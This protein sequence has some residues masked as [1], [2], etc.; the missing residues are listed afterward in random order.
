MKS[1]HPIHVEVS[2][3][4]HDEPLERM[5]KRFTKKMKKH[6]ILEE[7]RRKRYYEK[8]SAKRQRMA[9]ERK[10][11]LNKLRAVKDKKEKIR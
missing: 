5:I 4:Y 8:P 2:P 11:V 1:K 3:K 10:K 6:K 9:Q 7:V